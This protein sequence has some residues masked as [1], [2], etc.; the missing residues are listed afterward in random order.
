MP[1]AAETRQNHIALLA[2]LLGAVAIGSSPIFVR[3]SEI[4][5]LSTAFWRVAL[6]LLPFALLTRTVG[7]ADERP[8][9]LRDHVLL[10]LP[11][12]FLAVDLGLWHLALHMTSVANATL[13]ANFAPVFVTFASW[14]FFRAR[15]TPV[16][17]ASLALSTIGVMV[18]QIGP[19][20]HGESQLAGD[21]TA[22]L[23]AVF[24]AGYLLTLSRIRTR[25]STLRIMGWS[26]FSAA[27]CILPAALLFE[28]DFLPMTVFGWAVILGLALITHAGGQGLI[29]YA[30]AYLPAAFSSLTLLLQPVVAAFLAWALLAEPVGIM[31]ALGGVIVLL[32]IFIARRG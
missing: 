11:G 6:A 31:Q 1:H 16:F 14:L 3:I 7:K 15:I 20:S 12:M 5:P 8:Q 18:M 21:A 9:G 30:L 25:F 10:L 4:G 27:I 13:Y 2:L 26:T 19:A 29:T 24:Y 17:V 22:M 28:V 32:G 23:A